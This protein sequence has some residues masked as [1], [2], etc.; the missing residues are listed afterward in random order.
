MPDESRLDEQIISQAVEARLSS[1]LEEIEDVDVEVHTDLLKVAQGKADS[2]SVSG[3]GM[4]VQDVRLQ[5]VEVQTDR[6]AINP[7]SALFGELKLD[8]PLDATARMTLTEADVNRAVNSEMVKRRLPPLKLDVEGETVTVELQY[9]MQVKLPEKNKIGLT[10]EALLH[11]LKGTRRVGF[12]VMV[13]TCTD[14]HPVLLQAFQC[15]PDQSISLGFTI[16][17]MKKFQEILRLP[18]LEIDGVALRIIDLDVQAGNLTVQ[19]E[20]H[21]TEVPSL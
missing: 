21:V 3:Q 14:E 17:L 19:T 18:Y 4:V 2:I 15:S 13:L 10:G 1:Q 9:P 20:A 7:L 8:H 16:A 11:E 6:V 5:E 12:S